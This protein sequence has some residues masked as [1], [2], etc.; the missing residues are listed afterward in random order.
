[1][2]PGCDGSDMK[3]SD[4]VEEM[5]RAGKHVEPKPAGGKTID[6]R[7]RPVVEELRDLGLDVYS[8]HDTRD[9]ADLYPGMREVLLRHL[10]RDYPT[11]IRARMASSLAGKKMGDLWPEVVKRYRAEPDGY[12]KDQF[13]DALARSSGGKHLDDIIELISDPNL[14]SSR[15]MLVQ[16]L[17]RSRQPRAT[18][19]LESLRD[20]PD[21][22]IEINHR[23]RAR[24]SRR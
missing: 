4:L 18:A 21:L 24:R 17:T 16:A 7:H 6:E 11:N 12:V 10:E 19:T 8:V 5:K 13:A 20:D 9:K 1:M 2:D 15:V 22:T 3:A 14:G 23:L